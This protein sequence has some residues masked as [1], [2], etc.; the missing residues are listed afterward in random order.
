MDCISALGDQ[1][2][3]VYDLAG[4]AI[5]GGCGQPQAV[6]ERAER[7]K[8][9]LRQK[10]LQCQRQADPKEFSALRID[11]NVLSGNRKRQLLFQ[12]DHN[13]KQNAY[14]LSKNRGNRRTGCVH[15]KSGDQQQIARDVYNAGHQ[16]KQQ[17]RTAVAKPSENGGE[18]V[19]CN[20]EKDSAATDPN[21]ACGEFNRFL[22]SLHYNSDR[23]CK[24]HQQDEKNCRNHAEYH[25]GSAENR[26]DP[27]FVLFAEI[28]CNQNR[29]AHGEL[30]DH[31][32]DKIQH[33]TAG[34]NRRQSGGRAELTDNQQV[35]CAVGRLQ[36]QCA[37][38]WKHEKR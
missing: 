3:K 13:R 29:H 12:Q 2:G 14:R 30:R 19:V 20:D 28:A 8:R 33:L 10:L 9:K 31:K 6:N 21:V 7:Q 26:A 5:A 36:D 32:C 18:E 11:A 4:N 16:H 27:L 35:N 1:H 22:R 17:W 24:A 23:P 15:P 38:D 34:G 25:C 37:E